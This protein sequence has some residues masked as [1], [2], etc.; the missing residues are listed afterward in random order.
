MKTKDALVLVCNAASERSYG[1]DDG[2]PGCC[3]PQ[4]M[5]LIDAAVR[6]VQKLL[7]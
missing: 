7:K 6:K 1:A 3:S 5:K 2:E 4:D